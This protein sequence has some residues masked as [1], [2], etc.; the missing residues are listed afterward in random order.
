MRVEKSKVRHENSGKSNKKMIIPFE[1]SV[2]TNEKNIF[3]FSSWIKSKSNIPSEIILWE[4]AVPFVSG[5]K[6]FTY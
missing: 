1:E 3:A 5:V 6:L 4:I 2:I